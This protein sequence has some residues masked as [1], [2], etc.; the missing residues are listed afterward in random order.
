MSTMMAL[1]DADVHEGAESP[2]IGAVA[3]ISGVIA[4]IGTNTSD[5]SARLKRRPTPGVPPTTKDK[6]RPDPK[7]EGPDRI[8][9]LNPGQLESM[10]YRMAAKTYED[11]LHDN[12][13]KPATSPMMVTIQARIAEKKAKRARAHQII[14]ATAHYG[15]DLTKTGLKGKPGTCFGS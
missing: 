2:L 8:K 14:S 5:F 13:K 15:G 10:A 9:T 7:A 6:S 1:I 3:T 4:T 12:F 11:E